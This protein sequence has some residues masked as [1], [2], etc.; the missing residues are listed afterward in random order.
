MFETI[1]SRV[2]EAPSEDGPFQL[3]ISAIDH[4]RYVGR[5]GIGRIF[6]G[7]S[8]RNAPIVKI[9]RDGD[10]TAGLRLTTLLTFAGLE[11]IDVEEA[12]AGDIVCVGG[13][14]DLNIS[15][16]IADAGTPESIHAVSVDEPTVSMFFSVNNSPFA[17]LE[18]KYLTSRQV[19]ARLMRELES[20]VALDRRAHV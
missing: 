10:I 15:D 1:V 5:I 9:G 6:R 14:D 12:S 4:N 7:T 11:R 19:R 17:G 2:P 3:L 13:I 20:N 18:G 8:R 16:T